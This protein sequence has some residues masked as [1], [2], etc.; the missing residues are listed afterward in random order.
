M[1]RSCA[2]GAAAPRCRAVSRQSRRWPGRR[3]NI[4]GCCAA[5]TA[6]WEA[7]AGAVC[8]AAAKRGS[9]SASQRA[10]RAARSQADR[11]QA[12]RGWRQLPQLLQPPAQL[13]CPLLLPPYCTSRISTR[14]LA[15]VARHGRQ[16]A[17]E[18]GG[19]GKRRLRIRRDTQGGQQGCRR[20]GHHLVLAKLLL[21]QRQL[22]QQKAS[23]HTAARQSRPLWWP[24]RRRRQRLMQ[25]G[26]PHLA[27]VR[28]S[29]LWLLPP[30]RVLATAA[31][32]HGTYNVRARYSSAAA[33]RLLLTCVVTAAAGG[34]QRRQRQQRR[35]RR[36]AATAHHS[37]TKPESVSCARGASKAQT[38][39]GVRENSWR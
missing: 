26:R 10:G 34:R 38:Q 19:Q 11:R 23:L 37:S 31:H 7:V 4:A 20:L 17:R 18:G 14:P 29:W 16:G 32:L 2:P 33:R 12:Q 27:R 3:I 36:H 9:S 8:A 21:L 35:P 6:G 1:L 30:P 25:R 24:G 5:S 28:L 39:S 15:E 22:V 13:P